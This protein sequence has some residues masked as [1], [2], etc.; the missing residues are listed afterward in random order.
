MKTSLGLGF[1]TF[2][3][4]LQLQANAGEVEHLYFQFNV[5]HAVYHSVP[6]MQSNGEMGAEIPVICAWRVR[7]LADGE[8]F[9]DR[10]GA[11][12]SSG[13]DYDERRCSTTKK[14]LTWTEVDEPLRGKLL[15]LARPENRAIAAGAKLLFAYMNQGTSPEGETVL[16]EIAVPFETMR[17]LLQVEN[18]TKKVIK[19]NINFMFDDINHSSLWPSHY[20]AVWGGSL[21]VHAY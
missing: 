12:Y 6:R 10:Y 7:L 13:S 17:P 19:E 15:E 4:G 11:N 16:Q 5:E 14:S 18:S 1:L 8:A 2:I 21:V 9:K 20:V 3:L